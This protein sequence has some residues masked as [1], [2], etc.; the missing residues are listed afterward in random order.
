[1]EVINVT[2]KEVRRT[3]WHACAVLTVLI[4]A[5]RLPQII[6]AVAELLNR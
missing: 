4:V 1:M 2:P 5:F 6:H 3:L